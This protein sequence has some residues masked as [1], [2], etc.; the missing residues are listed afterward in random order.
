MNDKMNYKRMFNNIWNTQVLTFG[1]EIRAFYKN[2]LMLKY[3]PFVE[4][5]DIIN[6]QSIEKGVK[7]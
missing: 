3:Y 1:Y 2:G 6:N 4:V 5:K 7:K